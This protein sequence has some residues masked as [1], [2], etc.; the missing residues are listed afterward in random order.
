MKSFRITIA[1]TDRY[2][3]DLEYNQYL[4]AIHIPSLPKFTKSVY[5]DMD[6]KFKEIEQ[7][8]KEV[9]YKD[10]WVALDPSKTMLKK[11]AEK[12]GFSYVGLVDGLVVLKKGLN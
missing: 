2:K 3:V 6:L 7:F 5:F 10:L 1:E 9:G 8:C 11:F 4:V 12:L